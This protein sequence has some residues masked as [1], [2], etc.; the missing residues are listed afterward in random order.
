MQMM[1]AQRASIN[2]S[3]Q[4]VKQRQLAKLFKWFIKLKLI[5]K[6][7]KANSWTVNLANRAFSLL[8]DGPA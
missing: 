6:A 2:S 7:N 3:K 5:A 4:T 1:R 8:A